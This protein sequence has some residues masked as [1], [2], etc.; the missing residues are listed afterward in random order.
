MER[1]QET[2]SVLLD[3]SYYLIYFLM[4]KK[5]LPY[6]PLPFFYAIFCVSAAQLDKS[7][8]RSSC[9]FFLVN[10]AVSR[11][12]LSLSFFLIITGRNGKKIFKAKFSQKIFKGIY[13][14]QFRIKIHV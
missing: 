9:L 2:N 13:S 11:S 12:I 4:S 6:P 10:D 3:S 5:L 14:D 1:E 7:C 8:K